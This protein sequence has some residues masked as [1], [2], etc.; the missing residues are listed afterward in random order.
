M[1]RQLSRAVR[2]HR[3]LLRHV[4]ADRAQLAHLRVERAVYCAR[5]RL[6]GLREAH[7][8]GV[9][10]GPGSGST[11][12]LRPS[13]RVVITPSTP[14]IAS[15][16]VRNWR[17][18]PLLPGTSVSVLAKNLFNRAGWQN[19]ASSLFASTLR[20]PSRCISRPTSDGGRTQVDAG[21]DPRRRAYPHLALD[22]DRRAV[23]PQRPG[24][25]A[26]RVVLGLAASSLA[27]ALLRR[28]R[29]S[30]WPSCPPCPR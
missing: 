30:P 2:E 24:L 3:H 17:A 16:I 1:S 21:G 20:L 28:R 15:P 23:A 22:A 11:R 14:S 29:P 7:F 19:A 6:L 13:V 9:P 18:M 26:R 5:R 8:E 25:L 12:W 4:G 27:S 10:A